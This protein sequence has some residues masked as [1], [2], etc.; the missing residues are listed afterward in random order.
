MIYY[1]HVHLIKYSYSFI[2]EML[3]KML[4]IILERGVSICGLR[5]NR[6]MVYFYS[7]FYYRWIVNVTIVTIVTFVTYPGFEPRTF[8]LAVSIANHYTI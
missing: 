8:G 7:I 5:P 1:G 4:L 6:D 3:Q 2:E